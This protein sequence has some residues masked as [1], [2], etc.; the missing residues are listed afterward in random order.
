MLLWWGKITSV[1]QARK[2]AQVPRFVYKSFP[3]FYVNW[4]GIAGKQRKWPV[5]LVIA[6]FDGNYAFDL[7]RYM[8]LAD[9]WKAIKAFTC[10][11]LN[12]SLMW[13]YYLLFARITLHAQHSR[14]I[15]HLINFYKDE[16][17]E[18]YITPYKIPTCTEISDVFYFLVFNVYYSYQ[19][20]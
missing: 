19:K 15:C 9:I 6:S 1:I 7:E 11:V 16:I 8:R 3:L 13:L 12:F 17:G 4:I 14:I 18:H 20:I 2:I 5:D 10:S